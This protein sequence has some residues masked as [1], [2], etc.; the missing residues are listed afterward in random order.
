MRI[1]GGRSIPHRRHR[2]TL[3][4]LVDVI[5]HGYRRPNM[6]STSSHLSRNA[7]NQDLASQ[8]VPTGLFTRN[9]FRLARDPPETG[10]E[11]SDRLFT[12]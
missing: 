11:C 2:L 5:P 10:G 7:T 4:R 8:N 3:A 9:N 1:P 12:L 6:W